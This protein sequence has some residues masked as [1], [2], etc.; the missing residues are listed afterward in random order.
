MADESSKNSDIK[1][2]EGRAQTISK[3]NILEV[4][5][6]GKPF[7]VLKEHINNKKEHFS[8]KFTPLV[9]ND[10]FALSDSQD[11][12]ENEDKDESPNAVL[13]KFIENNEEYLNGTSK[14]VV[15]PERLEALKVLPLKKIE[16]IYSEEL[17]IIEKNRKEYGEICFYTNELMFGPLTTEREKNSNPICLNVN[18]RAIPNQN[19]NKSR[20]KGHAY[21]EYFDS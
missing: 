16:Q 17:G 6:K 12:T 9:P 11:S 15:F 8:D 4:I 14:D 21:I 2:M 19:K 5:G 7:T 20:D 18:E 1:L 3:Y 10:I 13:L